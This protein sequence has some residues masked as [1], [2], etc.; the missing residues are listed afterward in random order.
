MLDIDALNAP[1]TSAFF[2]VEGKNAQSKDNARRRGV[3]PAGKKLIEF[4]SI[5]CQ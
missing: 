1:T 3:N 5:Y 2:N 4:L